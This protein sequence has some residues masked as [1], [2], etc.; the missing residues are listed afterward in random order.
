MSSARRMRV[1]RP[2]MSGDIMVEPRIGDRFNEVTQKC[3]DLKEKY[4]AVLGIAPLRKPNDVSQGAW[5]LM[6]YSI[7][8]EKTLRPLRVDPRCGADLPASV[9]DWVCSDIK[10]NLRTTVEIERALDAWERSHL[11]T[12]PKVS[13]QIPEEVNEA[14]AR[15]Y[16]ESFK[17]AVTGERTQSLLGKWDIDTAHLW[18]FIYLASCLEAKEYPSP[19]GGAISSTV[20]M[21]PFEQPCQRGTLTQRAPLDALLKHAMSEPMA[22]KCRRAFRSR[23][24][25]GTAS[26]A[27]WSHPGKSRAVIHHFYLR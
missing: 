11:T 10:G 1:A 8:T 17:K 14:S 18:A 16:C 20:H 4:S 12:K 15:A 26:A 9:V 23:V 22:R 6:L 13:F 25:T 19:G 3:K 2:N 27:H 7:A 21:P 24:D 5:Q